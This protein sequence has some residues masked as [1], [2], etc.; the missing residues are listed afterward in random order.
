MAKAAGAA[1]L[2]VGDIDRGGV[3]ASLLGT[4]ELPGPGEREMFKGFLINK[5]RGDL[6]LLQPGVE[7]MERRLGLPCVGVVPYLQAL[8]LDEEDSVAVEDRLSVGRS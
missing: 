8:G 7:M 4:M 1:C 2:L 6:S 3:F 5:F